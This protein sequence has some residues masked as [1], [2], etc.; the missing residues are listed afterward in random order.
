MERAVRKTDEE[1]TGSMELMKKVEVKNLR[2]DVTRFSPG[3]TVRVHVKVVE[4]EKERTQ[5]F[6]GTVVGRRGTG[7]GATFT[8]RKVSGGVGVE[9]IFPVHSPGLTKIEVMK[10]GKV[11]RA[12]LFYLRGKKGKAAKITE[13][14]RDAGSGA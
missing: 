2:A 12:K 6:Q 1:E 10:E 3:D 8:V 5:I 11:S 7:M 14:R 4:G 13:R 9:R